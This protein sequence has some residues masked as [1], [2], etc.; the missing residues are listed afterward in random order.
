[1]AASVSDFYRDLLRERFGPVPTAELHRP[2]P[3]EVGNG[4]PDTDE[5]IAERRRICAEGWM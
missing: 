5:V 2:V 1:M 4:G 3:E